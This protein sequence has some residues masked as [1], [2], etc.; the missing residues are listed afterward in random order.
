[1][2]MSTTTTET[3]VRHQVE[4]DVPVDRAFAIFT[5]Q[6]DKIKPRDHNLLGSPI[7]ESVFE[8]RVGG[9][10]Y[11]RGEDGSVCAWARVLAFDP[12]S[13]F[14]I[15]WDISPQWQIETD[16]E[17]CS[18]VE[19]TFTAVDDG[20]TRVELEHRNL[21][22]H[23]AGWQNERAGVSGEGGWPLYLQRFADA[24]RA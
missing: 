24:T 9:R 4:V 12:P 20:R 10:V 11:D 22:H 7:A 23:G 15:S 13:R 16:P 3:A 5:E 18:E 8:P 17:H 2:I 14:V 6:F 19:V 21:D 1:M